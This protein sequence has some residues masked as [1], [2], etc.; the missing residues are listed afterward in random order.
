MFYA[1]EVAAHSSV[2]AWRITWTGESG[3]LQCSC[4][5]N[6]MDRGVWQAA[7]NGVLKSWT[8]LSYFHFTIFPCIYVPHI[9]YPFVSEHLGCCHVLPHVNSATKTLGCMYHFEFVFILSGYMPRIGIAA[10]CDSSIFSSLWNLHAILQSG[11][12]I[13]VPSNSVGGF[14]FLH[15]LSSIYCL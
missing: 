11:S 7:G 14:S 4:L 5:E 1:V 10:S 2:L 6:Y 15:T 8:Q 3:R 12:T 13:Y 9:L